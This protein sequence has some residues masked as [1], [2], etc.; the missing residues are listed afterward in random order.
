[1]K[2]ILILPY[3]GTL[4]KYFSLY[5]NSCGCNKNF[6]WLI[7][8]DDH[9]NY[10]YPPNVRVIYKSFSD[11]RE[12]IQNKFDF[13][14][15]LECPQKLCDYKP[16]Y[17]YIF[18]EYVKDYQF[19]GHCDPD[20]IWG[21]LERFITPEILQKYDKVFTHGHLT[22]YRNSEANNIRFTYAC[23]GESDYYKLVFS[24]RKSL[25]FDEQYIKSVNNIYEDSGFKMYASDAM[26]DIDPYHTNLRLSI[27][28]YTKRKY[29]L[30]TIK[31]QVFVWADGEIK[32]YYKKNDKIIEQ[33][34]AYI[35]LQKRE[36]ETIVWDGSSWVLITPKKFVQI[37]RGIS[38]KLLNH[39]H[40]SWINSQFF[41]VK[42]RFLIV[43]LKH[44]F[45]KS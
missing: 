30:E 3:F 6:N 43:K 20:C 35:H 34:F 17:G 18:Q 19:W 15:S 16:A 41:K 44:F 37:K 5:L 10:L 7:I 28:D 13:S 39:Y 29:L 1:M 26:A 12:M 8:T 4:P 24:T 45:N 31:K 14:I 40:Y 22:L 38:N 23:R 42:Y 36:M 33:Y 11:V 9:T 32:R 2:V 27:F 25:I 21:N